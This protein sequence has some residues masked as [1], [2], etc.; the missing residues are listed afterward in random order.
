MLRGN[1]SKK[2][3]SDDEPEGVAGLPW[4]PPEGLGT[5]GTLEWDRLAKLLEAERR[6]YA[7]D[8]AH[9]AIA[10]TAYQDAMYWRFQAAKRTVSLEDRLRIKRTERMEWERYRKAVNDLCLSQGTR[11]R[12]KTAGPGKASSRMA[13]YLANRKQKIGGGSV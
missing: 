13:D 9:L 12:A 2:S 8:G 11:A 10:A 4:K 3:F 7:S 6:L 5:R 1:P